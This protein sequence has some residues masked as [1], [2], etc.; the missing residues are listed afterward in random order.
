VSQSPAD[1]TLNPAQTYEDYFVEYQFRPWT[2]ELLAR[3][4]PTPGQRVLDVACGTGIVA[5]TVARLVGSDATVTGLDLSPAMIDV[6]RVAADRD[7][8]AIAWHVGRAEALPFPECVFDLVLI[9]QGLQFFPDQPA[10]AKE[11]FRVLAPGG[12]LGTATWAE[13]SAHPIF[14]ALA[15][16]VEK[17]LGIPAMHAAFSLGNEA[18]L[19]SVLT[20]AGFGNIDIERVARTV[21]YPDPSRFIELSLASVAAA[22]PAMQGMDVA[23]RT[24]LTKAVR[25]DMTEPLESITVGDEVVIPMVAHIAVA[26][27]PA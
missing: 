8:V 16:V 10:A 7:V 20:E 4:I 14:A 17:Y 12:R 9:Q 21:R 5:R 26:Q 24:R 11:A 6:A 2:E 25:A 23:E 15:A 27:R 18:A 1:P 19:R 3:A 22:V 13:I